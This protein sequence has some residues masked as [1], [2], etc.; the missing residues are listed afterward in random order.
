MHGT[1]IFAITTKITHDIK[2]SKNYW[3]PK[4]IPLPKYSSN[5]F[6][7]VLTLQLKPIKNRIKKIKKDEENEFHSFDVLGKLNATD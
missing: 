7:C 1:R 5:Y 4:T 6:Q 3:N 2:C